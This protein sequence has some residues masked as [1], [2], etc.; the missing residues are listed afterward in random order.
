MIDGKRI[1]FLVLLSAETAK[2][3]EASRFIGHR[4]TEQFGGVTV[5]GATER[6]A[7]TGYW[8]ED[9]NAFTSLYKGDITEEPVFGI[10]L[11]VLP[12]H[13]ERAFEQI[14]LIVGDA[15]SEFGLQSR[16]IHVETSEVRARHF[17]VNSDL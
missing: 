9:G 11:T 1:R 5:L 10:M 14:R 4:L 6:S 15:V 13:E 7:L 2:I 8:A 3:P 16:F 12:E 17:E